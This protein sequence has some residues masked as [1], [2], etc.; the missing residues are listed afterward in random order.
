MKTTFK[1]IVCIL[2][3]IGFALSAAD[4]IVPIK[5]T[6]YE[7]NEFDKS[8]FYNEV[9]KKFDTIYPT[10]FVESISSPELIETDKFILR[11]FIYPALTRLVFKEKYFAQLCNDSAIYFRTTLEKKGQIN[12]VY[13]NIKAI[14]KIADNSVNPNIKVSSC[15]L[16]QIIQYAAYELKR[17]LCG[18]ISIAVSADGGLEVAPYGELKD[19]INKYRNFEK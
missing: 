9:T 6:I 17:E 4:Q 16:L 10:P 19:L 12:G 18:R 7:F 15:V 3:T 1:F 13:N 14:E 11:Q 2:S 5:E 8:V